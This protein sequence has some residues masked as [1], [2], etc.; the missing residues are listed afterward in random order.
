MRLIGIILGM[1][2][3]TMAERLSFLT[4]LGRARVPLIVTRALRLVPAAVLSALIW[5]G[6]LYRG[7]VP[8]LSLDNAR[9]WAG[10]VAAVVAWRTRSVWLTLLVGMG[11]LLLMQHWL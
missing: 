7:G 4:W 10:L 6:L 8:D 5:P 2:A 11:G 9:L 3:V 1:A